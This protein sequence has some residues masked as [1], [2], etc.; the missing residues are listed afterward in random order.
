MLMD[1]KQIG[2]LA[3][4]EGYFIDV[5]LKVWRYLYS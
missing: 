2:K 3:A 4:K 1:W 5:Y